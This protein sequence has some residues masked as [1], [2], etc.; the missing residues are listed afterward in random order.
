MLQE[1]ARQRQV[2]SASSSAN[3]SRVPVQNAQ[4]AATVARGG[5]PP[6]RPYWVRRRITHT[7]V[8]SVAYLHLPGHVIHRN[9]RVWV[10]G[11]HMSY[12]DALRREQ[13]HGS[14]SK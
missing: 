8:G 3:V 13:P 4:P 11:V 7:D 6:R 14:S 12:S 9:D 5:Q 1:E 2:A 10:S